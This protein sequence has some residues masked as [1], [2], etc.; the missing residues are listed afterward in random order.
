MSN[1]LA[2]ESV[3]Q[4]RFADIGAAE[5][6]DLRGSGSREMLWVCG[7]LE[8]SYVE[9]HRNVYFTTETEIRR[10]ARDRVV[11]PFDILKTSVFSPP[12]K[13]GLTIKRPAISAGLQ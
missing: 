13:M 6:C 1:L 3:D 12:V 10:K 9:F 8:E 5:K 2:E 11:V 4:T 7:G